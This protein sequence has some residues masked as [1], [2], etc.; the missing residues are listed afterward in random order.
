M[1]LGQNDFKELLSATVQKI[2]KQLVDNVFTAHPTLD[3]LKASIKSATGPAVVF[4]IVAADDS[5][6]V[7]TDA[8]GTFK[9]PLAGA[10]SVIDLHLLV[11]TQGF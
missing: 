8:S 11:L 9:L 6:T 7:F 5:S 10:A 2:E 1:A 4:P 3:F